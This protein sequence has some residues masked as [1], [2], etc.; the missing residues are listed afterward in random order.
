MQFCR[1][2]FL[3]HRRLH[4]CG[5]CLRCTRPY[6]I[7]LVDSGPLGTASRRPHRLLYTWLRPRQAASFKAKVSPPQLS[8]G[9]ETDDEANL[10]A[11]RSSAEAP[12]RV[13]RPD[14]D[15]GRPHDPE[16]AQ[17]EGPEAALGL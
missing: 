4:S 12:A 17:G 15:S 7:A 10:P 11:E 8:G 16:A 5:K 3:S 2:F 14:G 1:Q 13:S 9:M 6:G